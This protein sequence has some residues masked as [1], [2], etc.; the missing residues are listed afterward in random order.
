MKWL[1]KYMVVFYLSG[2]FAAGAVSGWVVADHK[3][4]AKVIVPPRP[5]EISKSFKDR[6]HAKLGLTE[7]QQRRIDGIIDRSSSDIQAVQADH[8]KSLRLLLDNRN[9]QISGLLTGEQQQ[10]FASL[11]RERVEPWKNRKWDRSNWQ[12]RGRPGFRGDAIKPKGTNDCLTN[13]TGKIQATR[14]EPQSE[15]Q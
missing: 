5:D 1:S 2:I 6:V 4:K 8:M 7:E 3:A 14:A 11:V 15:T 12:S 9:S 13:S 10:L